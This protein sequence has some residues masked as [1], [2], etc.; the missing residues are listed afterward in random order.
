MSGVLQS[1]EI[2]QRLSKY[3]QF[4]SRLKVRVVT[5]VSD[6]IIAMDIFQ[7]LRSAVCAS[8]IAL[9]NIFIQLKIENIFQ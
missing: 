9:N 8:I 2:R 4:L 1:S 3:K 5:N 6:T 7:N